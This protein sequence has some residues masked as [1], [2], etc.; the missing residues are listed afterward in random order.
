MMFGR[1]GMYIDVFILV[2]TA[3][4]FMFSAFVMFV[5]QRFASCNGAVSKMW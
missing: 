2:S 5:E 4:L 1:F 3:S